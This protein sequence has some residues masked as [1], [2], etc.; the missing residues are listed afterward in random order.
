MSKEKD[1]TEEAGEGPGL[2]EQLFLKMDR[3][4]HIIQQ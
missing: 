2:V 4:L 3:R 1:E